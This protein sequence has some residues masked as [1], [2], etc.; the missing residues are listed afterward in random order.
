[1]EKYTH[2]CVKC[3]V[4]YEDSDPDPYYCTSCNEEKI[5]IAKRIDEQMANR[6]PKRN[7]VSAL[8]EYD[9]A[10]KAHGFVITTLNG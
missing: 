1:M 10:P 9:S 2:N 5:K 8:Q 7:R 6:P 3:S 4:Q